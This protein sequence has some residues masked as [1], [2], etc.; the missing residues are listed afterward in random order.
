MNNVSAL[1]PAY[2]AEKTIARALASCYRQVDEII[3]VNDGSTDHTSTVVKQFRHANI[4][5]IN[6]AKNKGIGSARQTCLEHCTTQYAAWLDSDDCFLPNRI[7]DLLPWL[8]KGYDIVYDNMELFCGTTGEFLRNSEIDEALKTHSGLDRQFARNQLRGIGV[9]LANVARIRE[10]GY[11]DLRH[12]E[13][14]DFL[15]RALLSGFRIKLTGSTSYRQYIYPHSVSNSTVNQYQ[16]QHQILSSIGYQRLEKHLESS[17]LPCSDI[18]RIKL[19]FLANIG[20]WKQL[21]KIAKEQYST[22]SPCEHW[23]ALFME[24]VALAQSQLFFDASK[25]FI[26]ALNIEATPECFNNLAVCCFHLSHDYQEHLRY[27]LSLKPDYL[28]AENNLNN[29]P[30]HITRVPLRRAYL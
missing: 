9:P 24:G 22:K 5:L 23:L 29:Y 10:L 13:D 17:A 8:Q 14:Y 19:Y 1:I 30:Q 27:A 3:V 28:D 26:A 6:H 15:L 12:A 7:T 18:W 25:K 11:G 2:N 21:A 20:D 4:R 16:H